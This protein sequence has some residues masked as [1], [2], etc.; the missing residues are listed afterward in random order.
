MTVGMLKL[1]SILLYVTFVYVISS[2]ITIFVCKECDILWGDC[3]SHAM[4][5]IKPYF[6][7]KTQLHDF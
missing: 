1:K 6:F 4:V 2:N 3:D 7:V 5:H